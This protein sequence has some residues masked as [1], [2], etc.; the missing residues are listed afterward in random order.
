MSQL[1]AMPLFGV[2]WLEA[3]AGTGK[4]YALSALYLRLLL[5]RGLAPAA[6]PMLTFSRAASHELQL[7]LR[8]RLHECITALG[9][10]S[11]PAPDDFLREWLPGLLAQQRHEACL[12]RIRAAQAE[13]DSAPI[14]TI[15][16]FAQRVLA[17]HVL[18]LGLVASEPSEG[19]S[20]AQLSQFLR[21]S[22]LRWSV[23]GVLAWHPDLRTDV[24]S[25][26]KPREALALALQA[27]RDIADPDCALALNALA[28]LGAQLG[29][30][31]R[32]QPGS[33][34]CLERLP[35]NQQ[36]A[37][38]AQL[39]A[40][41]IDAFEQGLLAAP[42]GRLA[43]P[44]A[45]LR[46]AVKAAARKNC[47][48]ECRNSAFLARLCELAR[49]VA[50]LPVQRVL[51][52]LVVPA[53]AY[54]R[55]LARERAESS[56]DDAIEQLLAAC[57]DRGFAQMLA[58]RF[59]VLLLDEAQDSDR[60]QFSLMQRLRDAGSDLLIVGDPKQ[61]IYGFRGADLR[62]FFAN[63]QRLQAQ[64][65]SL[66]QNFRSRELL[67]A[68]Q[69]AL[70]SGVPDP[71]ADAQLRFTPVQ[72]AAAIA[73][74]P[75]W[76]GA[77]PLPGITACDFGAPNVSAPSLSGPNV[78]GP[79]FSALNVSGPNFDGPDFDG[80]DFDGPDLTACDLAGAQ[81]PAEPLP[82]ALAEQAALRIA[83]WLA[84]D[85]VRVGSAQ[86]P[87]RPGQ[88]AVLAARNSELKVMEAALRK[89][90]IPYLNRSKPSVFDSAAAHDLR[91]LLHV[92]LHPEQRSL[93]RG[94]LL[95]TWFAWS[96]RELA[97]PSLALAKPGQDLETAR[98][99]L[100]RWRICGQ[101]FGLSAVLQLALAEVSPR[102]LAE[103]T[104]ARWVSDQLQLAEL[105]AQA[106]LV[107]LAAQLHWLEQ[108]M[109]DSSQ[110]DRSQQLQLETELESVQLMT[111]HAAKGLEFDVVFLPF[112][113]V[114]YSNR[115]SL[116]AWDQASVDPNQWTLLDSAS[117]ADRDRH[118]RRALGEDL[119]LLYVALTRARYALWLAY[120][121]VSSGRTSA[122]DHLLLAGKAPDAAA[123]STALADWAA[124]S[125]GAVQVQSSVN[126]ETDSVRYI[127]AVVTPQEASQMPAAG[128]ST[129]PLRGAYAMHSFSR[130]TRAGSSRNPLPLLAD[131]P[132]QERAFDPLRGEAFGIAVHAFL[133]QTELARWRGSR[134]ADVE[135]RRLTQVLHRHHVLASA[136]LDPAVLKVARWLHAALNRPLLGGRALSALAR[137]QYQVELPFQL[138]LGDV[139]R[140][141]LVDCIE[142]HGFDAAGFRAPTGQDRLQGMLSGVIDL[143]CYVD[144]CY[145]LVDYKTNWLGAEPADYDAAAMQ[146]AVSEH[147]YHLQGMLYACA[148]WRWLRQRL[149][150]KFAPEKH[151]GAAHLLFLRGCKADSTASGA[152]ALP[153]SLS[154]VAALDHVLSGGVA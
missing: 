24:R 88:I 84:A 108:N 26:K 119:R 152:L 40:A 60:R 43:W 52:S 2:Q 63:R 132:E 128:L 20:R 141:L 95:T 34:A 65:L 33:R 117:E 113:A 102:L 16:A 35:R 90:A 54:L 123:M 49:R 135:L 105:A 57:E 32:S 9:A 73:H 120:G 138:R 76:L 97:Q 79:N 104:G 30:L 38:P 71:F 82:E 59:P 41:Q 92:L 122:L 101:S 148:L 142:R 21:S 77:A 121:A 153:L 17:E 93:W 129:R 23:Q 110:S 25:L 99:Q 134:V 100:A 28:E 8:K 39:S 140:R 131:G 75:V 130:M 78:S 37:A 154:L 89:R 5:E 11:A 96:T 83:Q 147:H 14:M 53:R 116:P 81:Y 51:A 139:P 12:L 36:S 115:L 114:R 143:V 107:G 74:E 61:S 106:R 29:A 146:T 66:A 136:Q 50:E 68:A 64:T 145:H 149:G 45:T 103:P 42:G 150:R 70:F 109:L 94:L 127:P 72:A 31:Y 124:R 98:A 112:V 22:A 27:G 126:P 85:G 80:P 4:T 10:N 58:R 62:E 48:A 3:S 111:F 18:A 47:P 13:L 19:Q 6:I 15:H 44:A 1:L 86:A 91:H 118:M 46:A 87:L 125:G 69:D 151:F 144:G 56:F 133:E 55:R 7:R 137:H 67:L